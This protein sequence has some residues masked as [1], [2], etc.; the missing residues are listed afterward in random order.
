M[1]RRSPP[2]RLF[3]NRGNPWSQVDNV[4]LAYQKLA[5]LNESGA[6]DALSSMIRSI[7]A[8]PAP[9]G[10]D[11]DFER[12]RAHTSP[13]EPQRCV[14][15]VESQGRV[16]VGMGEKTPSENG[17]S[18]HSV[19]G[20]PILPGSSLKGVARAWCVRNLK[21]EDGWGEDGEHILNLFGSGGDLGQSGGVDFLD[22]LWVPG[23]KGPW[24]AEILTSHYAEYY[25]SGS[26]PHGMSDPNPVHF[27]AAEGLFR[28][29]IEGPGAW[30][31]LAMQILLKALA[32]DGVGAKTKVGYGRMQKRDS[33]MQDKSDEDEW[34][35]AF[36]ERHRNEL[37]MKLDSQAPQER[38]GT[39]VQHLPADKAL[40]TSLLKRLRGKQPDLS[41]WTD[42]LDWDD[43]AVLEQIIRHLRDQGQT[44]GLKKRL[45]NDVSDDTRREMLLGI[46]ADVG[47]KATEQGPSSTQKE[48]GEKVFAVDELELKYETASKR[49]KAKLPNAAAIVVSKGGYNEDS[50]SA[51]LIFF[52]EINAPEGTKRMVR[53]RYGIETK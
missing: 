13:T 39:L 7:A 6:A 41:E 47:T 2:T 35:Q 32:E 29:V 25:K 4:G 30:V 51:L 48:F 21:D 52:E 45:G 49:A 34:N 9:S 38:L 33:L 31:E 44:G 37:K 3:E 26:S 16:L 46:L 24:A 42:F 20:T 15:I 5:P 27:L 10:Y 23:R 17:L 36:V 11:T 43:R 1:T 18:L 53:D 40:E 14:V 8:R 28:L 12:W 50:V 22:A 19:Y